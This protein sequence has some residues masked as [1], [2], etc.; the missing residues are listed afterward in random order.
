MTIE[1]DENDQDLDYVRGLRQQVITGLMA[2]GVPTDQRELMILQGF[3]TDMSRDAMGKKRL[4]VEK[5]IGDK[6]A[7]AQALIATLLLNPDVKRIGRGEG[8]QIPQ[9]P[10]NLPEVQIVEGEFTDSG[11]ETYAQFMARMGKA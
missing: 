3:L 7:E 9:L 11:G 4:K 2:K 5:Q 1:R 8:G 10:H 6:T